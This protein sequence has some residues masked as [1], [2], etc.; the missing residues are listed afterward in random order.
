MWRETQQSIAIA[1]A[2]FFGVMP[3][4]VDLDHIHAVDR[5][6]RLRQQRFLDF[7]A[8]ILHP[9]QHRHIAYLK[10]PADGNES[11]SLLVE[12]QR[13]D[14]QVRGVSAT[15]GVGEVIA[16]A[17]ATV[18]LLTLRLAV[19]AIVVT[20]TMNAVHKPSSDRGLILTIADN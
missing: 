12:F 2:V 15:V 4:L 8:C 20:S 16:T 9:M 5:G 13:G 3:H 11:Q 10:K 19:A 17:P 6:G 14:S 1:G 18:P 7:L